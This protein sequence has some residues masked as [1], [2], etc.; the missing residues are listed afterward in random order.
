M[1]LYTYQ[2]L[3]KIVTPYIVTKKYLQKYRTGHV[4]CT[5]FLFRLDNHENTLKIL[6]NR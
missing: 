1:I 4:Y 3:G 5:S 6:I 2:K